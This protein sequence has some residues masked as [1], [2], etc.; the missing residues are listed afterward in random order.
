MLVA[1]LVSDGDP[2][3]MTRVIPRPGVEPKRLGRSHNP[4]EPTATQSAALVPTPRAWTA[5]AATL[6]LVYVVAG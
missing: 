5:A 3:A 4:A 1:G 2:S 6:L